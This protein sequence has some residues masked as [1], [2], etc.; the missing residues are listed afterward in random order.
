MLLFFL[1]KRNRLRRLRHFR[2]GEGHY[3]CTECIKQIAPL[4]VDESVAQKQLREE[5]EQLKAENGELKSENRELK[6]SIKK[7]LY[8]R[9]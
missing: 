8:A 7:S 3:H 2:Q 5:N 4:L 9:R 6:L 1:M